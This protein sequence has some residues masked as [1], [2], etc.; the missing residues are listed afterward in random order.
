M[1]TCA[2]ELCSTL[3]ALA[4]LLGLDTRPSHSQELLLKVIGAP[5]VVFSW[6]SQACDPWHIPD[7]PVRA[8]RL[9]DGNVR[10]LIAH[11]HNRILVGPNMNEMKPHCPILFQARQNDDPAMFDDRGWIV[12]TYT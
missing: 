11:Y 1:K 10:L 5:E 8:F 2:R 6:R 4:F 3:V 12:A 9:S 7:A